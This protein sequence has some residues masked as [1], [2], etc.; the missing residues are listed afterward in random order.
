[1]EEGWGVCF[2]VT[3]GG[4]NCF[5]HPHE[6]PA[7]LFPLVCVS[8][9]VGMYAFLGAIPHQVFDHKPRVETCDSNC[10]TRMH[11]QIYGCGSAC[12]G[13]SVFSR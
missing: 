9:H 11:L 8:V 1:M 4:S 2:A 3:E 13:A 6:V 7:I 10:F 5:I 12:M